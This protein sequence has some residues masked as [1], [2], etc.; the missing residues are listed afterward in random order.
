MARYREMGPG[1]EWQGLASCVHDE[2]C[3]GHGAAKTGACLVV[4]W[5]VL[6]DKYYGPTACRLWW[7]DL[8]VVQDVEELLWVSG[9]PSPL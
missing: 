4:V 1:G 7:V 3:I 9:L 8:Q 2:A 5:Q 6:G